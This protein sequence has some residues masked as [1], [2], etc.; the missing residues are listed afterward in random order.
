[1]PK[2]TTRRST[3]K[4]AKVL[5]HHGAVHNGVLKTVLPNGLTVVLKENH[6]APVATFWVWYRVGSGRERT[7]I[8]GIS[9]WVE[10]MLFKGTEKF[11]GRKADQVISREG[12]QWN[13]F[14]SQDFTTY[15][16]TLPAEKI[17]LALALEADRMVNAPF[18]P[19][20][21]SS[22]R[23]V[24]ISEKQGG[25]NSPRQLLG[26]EVQAAAF[27][28]HGYGH[29]TIGY[30]CDLQTMTRDDLY[31][32]YRTYYAPNNAVAVAVG[33]FNAQDML[34]KIEKAFG[35][36]KHGPAIPANTA[37]EPEQR[38]ERRV[39][40][41]GPG[42]TSYVELAYHAPAAKDADF[43]AMVALDAILAGASSLSIFGGG[44]TNASSRLYKALV[45]T[46]LATDV[47]GS[48]IPTMDPYLYG[49]SATVRQGHTPQEVE[50]AFDAEIDRMVNEPVQATELAKAI[51]Q[52][53]ASFAFGSESVTNQG[54][55]YGWSEV[56]AD[57]KWFE[58]YLDRL[59]AVTVADVQ[60]V[61]QKY[62]RR[63]NRV[64]GYYLPK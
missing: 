61:A 36:I 37:I 27:R 46:E 25:E 30:L 64:V 42:T 23:T 18:R 29:E 15:F 20:D 34:Q 9:H 33:A 17:D 58:T 11:P 39:N 41:E 14:T 19:R 35:K 32:H 52:A 10:H 54:F 26:E 7:G 28:A 50:A 24:I 13:G 21:V 8:T 40:V 57:Y 4:R 63:C 16:E 62:L 49:L 53:R 43:P 55:W 44:T 6:N 59:A 22:E 51:K 38:G 31:T 60:R 2:T 45:E 5:A 1:M 48:C 47:G 12:G 3:T 56:F